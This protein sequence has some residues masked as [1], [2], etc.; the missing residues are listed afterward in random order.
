M[1]STIAATAVMKIL[2][3]LNLMEFSSDDDGGD[4]DGECNGLYSV[5]PY[6]LCAIHFSHIM[7]AVLDPPYFLVDYM[8]MDIGMRKNRK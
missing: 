8:C 7:D 1:T 4:G 2:Q 3:P 6:G 5:V